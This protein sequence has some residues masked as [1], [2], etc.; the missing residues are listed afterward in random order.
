MAKKVKDGLK[1]KGLRN[2]KW[3]K[4]EKQGNE[5]DSYAPCHTDGSGKKVKSNHKVVGKDN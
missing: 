4:M 5:S 1:N 2:A 3:D